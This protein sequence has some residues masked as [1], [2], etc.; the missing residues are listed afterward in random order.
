[1]EMITNA[2]PGQNGVGVDSLLADAAT[3][4]D[5]CSKAAQQGHLADSTVS[6]ELQQCSRVLADL[7]ADRANTCKPP[8][9]SQHLDERQSAN[10]CIT[11][12][13]KPAATT[14]DPPACEPSHAPEPAPLAGSSTPA[15]SRMSKRLRKGWTGGPVGLTCKTHDSL[16]VMCKMA[17]PSKPAGASV[18]VGPREASAKRPLS[19]AVQAA[20]KCSR[21]DGAVSCVAPA[22]AA[23]TG[24]QG[25]VPPCAGPHGGASACVGAAPHCTR[26]PGAPA[27]SPSVLPSCSPGGTSAAA[28]AGLLRGSPLKRPAPDTSTDQQVASAP[29][30]QRVEPPALSEVSPKPSI[31]AE[32]VQAAAV[33]GRLGASDREGARCKVSDGQADL[34][35][36]EQAAANEPVAA[37]SEPVAGACTG[38]SVDLV[39]QTHSPPALG[40]AAPFPSVQPSH[41][42]L[43]AR[44]AGVVDAVA[45]SQQGS[46]V[47]HCEAAPPE[48]LQAPDSAQKQVVEG[49]ASNQVSPQPPMTPGSTQ[50]VGEP[51]DPA[52]EHAGGVAPEVRTDVPRAEESVAMEPPAA[53]PATVVGLSVAHCVK[54]GD[55]AEESSVEPRRTAATVPDAAVDSQQGSPLKHPEVDAEPSQPTAPGFAQQRVFQPPASLE[56]SPQ[57]PMKPASGQVDAA[58]DD[59]RDSGQQHAGRETP[60]VGADVPS[61]RRRAGAPAVDTEP[62]L[63]PRVMQGGASEEGHIGGRKNAAAAAGLVADVQRGPVMRSA[64]TQENNQTAVAVGSERPSNRQRAGREMPVVQADVPVVQQSTV[65]GPRAAAP[66]PVA[67]ASAGTR[68]E[69][70]GAC[71]AEPECPIALGASAPS[72]QPSLNAADDVAA[73]AVGAV[74]DSRRGSGA[75]PSETDAPAGPLEPPDSE[76]KRVQQPLALPE[77]SLKLSVTPSND[78]T[79]STAVEQGGSTQERPGGQMAQGRPDGPAAEQ[80]AM[81]H[82]PAAPATKAGPTTGRCVKQEGVAERKHNKGLQQ[83]CAGVFHLSACP[84]ALP[85]ATPSAWYL[86]R[87]SGWDA[88]RTG[89][90]ASWQRG[91]LECVCVC[92][93][94]CCTEEYSRRRPWS[95]WVLG[96]CRQGCALSQYR[97][98]SGHWASTRASEYR[99]A[100]ANSQCSSRGTQCRCECCRGGEW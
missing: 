42:A 2:V 83:H 30:R 50:A 91:S 14:G 29:V 15:R 90:E 92:A 88:G 7:K 55:A 77:V 51:G 86:A 99:H 40:A 9:P 37:T 11:A 27:R 71:A 8:A 53:A 66:E 45:G 24:G 63:A 19:V 36:A 54:E 84:T 98:G 100:V 74:A 85:V 22:P 93:C 39:V 44:A 21:T 97:P 89:T 48:Q 35:A 78:Q 6:R 73:A 31:R 23:V 58:G 64:I 17:D 41:N 96:G 38:A 25:C 5:A 95:G 56:V 94:R 13:D 32:N 12:E 10:S 87:L 70:G 18:S 47:R 69:Q 80:S 20:E 79:E 75:Q 3:A 82:P 57:A 81:M 28:A 60:E 33:A 49:P 52:R 67:G 34:P 59:Q 72:V 1:M 43:G 76:K 68:S 26:A 46:V 16:P 4:L 61:A 65:M 62:T